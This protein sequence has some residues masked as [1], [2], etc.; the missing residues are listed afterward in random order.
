M[1]EKFELIARWD[2]FLLKMKERYIESLEQA[3][4]ACLTQLEETDYDYYT[5]FR[6][7]QGMKAQ[8]NELL[9]KID[10]TWEETVAPKMKRIG[11]DYF[12][13]D[14]QR[15]ASELTDVL[16]E[17]M[18]RF[19]K[20]LEGKLSLKF[21]E[22]AIETV[23]HNFSCHQCGAPLTVKKDLF[24]AQYV[25]CGACNSVNTFEPSTKFMLIGGNIVDNI[26]AYRCLPL[27]DKMNEA[28]DVIHQTRKEQYT[29]S[30][31]ESYKD[32]YFTYWET[33]F[34]ERI[35]LKPAIE[36]RFQEDMERK[37]LEY[38]HYEKVHRY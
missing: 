10:V 20:V 23:N 2:A 19:Q 29:S 9:T 22:H 21:Y 32:T 14:E 1:G 38:Q 31:W 37:T 16:H 3:E 15:K 33:Y 17:K 27:H 13:L 36:K 11:E 12:Y 18:E 6:S 28:L 25:T 30:M 4:E 34:K 5:V 24:R 8:I 26:V 7:W 35:K